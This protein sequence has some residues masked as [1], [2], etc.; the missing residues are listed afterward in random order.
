[1][2]SFFD[3]HY[4]KYDRWYDKNEYVYLSE[5]EAVRK[6]V[7]KRGRGLEIGIGTSRFAS[8][9]KIKYGIDVSY[10]ML[11]TAK[12]RGSLV[13]LAK[14][15]V[16]PFRRESFDYA[17]IVVTICFVKAPVKVLEESF[18]V[19][20]KGGRIILGIVDEDSF[21]G[22]YYQTKKSIFYKQAIFFSIKSITRLLKRAGFGKF[23]YYQTIF[24]L[25]A[26]INTVEKTE[27]GFGRGGF[28]VIRG[29][30]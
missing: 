8:P 30:K 15:E 11:K 5:L 16:L 9:L 19:L 3:G 27:K 6:A 24:R 2:K 17:L 26:E 13:S 12:K 22:E 7:P 28:V 10:N 18:R 20:K 25:P 14:G 4:K 29:C 1:M 23:S 21:L